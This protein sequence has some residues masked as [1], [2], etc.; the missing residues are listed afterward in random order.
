MSASSTL[1]NYFFGPLSSQY[2]LLFYIMSVY[3][4]IVTIIIVVGFVGHMFSKKTT[5][6]AIFAF[7]VS[8]VSHLVIYVGYRLIYNMCMNSTRP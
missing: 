2:C 1:N 8:A 6:L 4:L 3:F 7:I 5:P